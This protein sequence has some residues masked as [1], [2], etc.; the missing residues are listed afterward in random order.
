MGGLRAQKH[1]MRSSIFQKELG[2][3]LRPDLRRQLTENSQGY[4][5]L[6]KKLCIHVYDLVQHEISQSELVD[7]A[8]DIGSLFDKDLQQLTSAENTCLQM[9][10]ENAPAD[11]Y[12][13]LKFSGQDVLGGLQDKRLI[14]RSGDRLNLYWDIFREYVLT[15][16]VPSIALSYL[17]SSPS[18]RAM[19]KVGTQL[20]LEES[21][22][23]VELSELCGL[24][25][26]KQ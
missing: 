20:D 10:A 2:E 9:I 8:L 15:Q 24:S 12:E 13:M 3:K 14:I 7:K 19:L 6:L 22:S 11:W 5:W 18:I 16:T 21:R 1:R 23:P 17:P 4:P 26:K 25:R